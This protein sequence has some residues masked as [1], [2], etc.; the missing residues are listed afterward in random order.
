[1]AEFNV[2][3]ITSDGSVRA[4]VRRKRK[5]AINEKEGHEIWIRKVRE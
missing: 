3:A 5:S 4:R 2:G 1:V